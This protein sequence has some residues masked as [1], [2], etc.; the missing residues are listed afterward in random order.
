MKRILIAILSLAIIG[1]VYFIAAFGLFGF[2][3]GAVI[4]KVP[5]PG[6]TPIVHGLEPLRQHWDSEASPVWPAARIMGELSE[7]AYLPPIEAIRKYEA[8]GFENC[9]VL[10]HNSMIGYVV[11]QN[12][13]LVVVFRGTNPPEL[14]D[15]FVNLNSVSTSTPNGPIHRGFKSAYLSLKP[16]LI[17]AVRACDAKHIWVTGH[18]L[19]GALAL[20]CVQDLEEGERMHIDGIVTFGQPMVAKGDL[21][22][23]LDDA[24]IGRYVRFVN[25]TDVVPRV[26]LSFSPCGRLVWFTDNGLKRSPPKRLMYGAPGDSEFDASSDEYAEIEPLS[27]GELERLK[28]RIETQGDQQFGSGEQPVLQ[29]G[30]SP[31]GDHSMGVYVSEVTQLIGGK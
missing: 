22:K 29:A 18:S 7:L 21:A 1:A 25:R 3:E 14:S 15:W 20:A 2:R 28:E 17:A 19:G 11:N 4:D 26:P 6:P 8:L 16:Q 27:R 23:H 12:D 30:F 9:V 24:L 5:V 31:L 13:I 10:S